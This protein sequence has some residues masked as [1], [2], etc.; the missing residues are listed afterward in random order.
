[1]KLLYWLDLWWREV[2]GPIASVTGLAEAMAARGHR[3]AIATADPRDAPEAWRRGGDGVSLAIL[4][5]GPWHSI[6]F[7]ARRKMTDLVRDADAIHFSGLWE[8]STVQLAAA[9]RRSA[10]PYLVS[11][12]GTLDDWAMSQSAVRKRLWMLGP[13]RALLGGAARVH[14]TSLGETR[15]AARWLRGRT[16]VVLPNL[17][18]L[19]GTGRIQRREAASFEVLLMGRLHPTKGADVLLDAVSRL[20][21]PDRPL[22]R[23]AGAGAEDYVAHLRRETDRLGISERVVFE[24][25]IGEARRLELLGRSWAMVLPSLQENFGNAIFEAISA[26]LPVVTTDRVDTAAELER[27]GGAMIVPRDPQRIADA[28]RTLAHDAALRDRMSEAGRAWAKRELDPT[29][30]A[31]AYESLYRS[32]AEATR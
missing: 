22:V 2:G 6:A 17:L 7:G 27:S 28:L 12:R 9:A 5:R 18:D 26:G 32:L 4:P 24:G 25:H 16:P 11:L 1:V 20:A 23:L 29:R 14:C 19:E 3:V 13:G 8:P 30:T 21:S 15:Q 10:V 31:A